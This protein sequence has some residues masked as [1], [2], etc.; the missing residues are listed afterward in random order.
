MNHEVIRTG[1]ED[2]TE[3]FIRVRNEVFKTQFGISYEDA[4]QISQWAGGEL[5]AYW[6]GALEYF[7]NLIQEGGDT[8]ET[9]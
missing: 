1:N 5:Q 2:H 8:H 3:E 9:K 7:N 4:Q 6:K